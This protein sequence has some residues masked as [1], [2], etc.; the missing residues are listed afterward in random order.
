MGRLERLRQR[1]LTGLSNRGFHEYRQDGPS[2]YS[3]VVAWAKKWENGLQKKH[4]LVEIDFAPFGPRHRP[5]TKRPNPF[6][7]ES[8]SR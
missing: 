2:R 6:E 7:Y 1:K 3:S 5:H 8:L 4:G